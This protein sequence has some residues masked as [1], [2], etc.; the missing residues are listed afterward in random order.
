MHPVFFATDQLHRVSSVP[1]RDTDE[2][3]KRLLA[4]RAEFQQSV[5]YNRGPTTGDCH[6]NVIGQG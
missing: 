5:V 2:L 6:Y 1:R 3:Q 4:T